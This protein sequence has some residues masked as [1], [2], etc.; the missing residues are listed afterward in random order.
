VERTDKCKIK[1]MAPRRGFFDRVSINAETGCWNCEG[2]A[3]S[4]GYPQ[5]AYCGKT[6]PASRIAAIC[7]LG[8]TDWRNTKIFV[9]H[10]CDNP[11][12]VNPKHLF[13][14]SNSDNIKD[15]VS[16]GFHWQTKKTHCSH[17][18][19]YSTEN[20]IIAT[21]RGNHRICKIC[22]DARKKRNRLAYAKTHPKLQ[23]TSCRKGHP[24]SKENT[25]Y[26][27]GKRYCRICG[28]I[29]QKKY[30]AGKLP[31]AILT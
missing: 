1:Q 11:R 30:R 10:K 20:T 7:W 4:G 3:M 26:L 17:G 14:G 6:L 8:F 21:T 9:C 5:M 12:C 19:L 22:D 18:H 27:G 31:A 2:S 28:K 15:Y 29:R 23:V 25:Y 16:K 13:L 24:Y